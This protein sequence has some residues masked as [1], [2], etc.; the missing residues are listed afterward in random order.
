VNP[1]RGVP[2]AA[3]DQDV[4][5]RLDGGSVPRAG[6][7]RALWDELCSVPAWPGQALWLHGD[8]HPAN[9]ITGGGRLAAVV[10]FGDLTAGDP[11]TDLAAAWLVFDGAGRRIFRKSLE[12]R[13][14]FDAETWR[15]ARG[16]ALNMATA[17]LANSD[18]SPL[19]RQVGGYA[20]GQ[21]LDQSP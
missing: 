16:W 8:L 7:A 14:D 11:A 17:L 13:R 9:L 12:V 6:E 18:D 5:R 20:L 2:L 4:R 15:R 3:R 10:D 19:L 1:V 21:V